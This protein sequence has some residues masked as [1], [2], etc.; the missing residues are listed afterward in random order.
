MTQAQKM[1]KATKSKK[2]QEKVVADVSSDEDN[3]FG[4]SFLQ[5]E[6]Q[7][8]RKHHFRH[9]PIHDRSRGLTTQQVYALS[10]NNIYGHV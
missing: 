5:V 1:I 4:D 2:A 6:S 10:A 8:Q 9:N 7:S 3:N